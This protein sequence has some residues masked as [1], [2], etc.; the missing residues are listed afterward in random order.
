MS[1]LPSGKM[2]FFLFNYNCFAFSTKS[3]FRF[4]LVLFVCANMTT[5]RYTQ[6]KKRH[7]QSIKKKKENKNNKRKT[8][9][10]LFFLK[11]NTKAVSVQIITSAFFC[12]NFFSI[13]DNHGIVSGTSRGFIIAANN[14]LT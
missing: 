9:K 6:R 11:K 10:M 4:L 12:L 14:V 3:I 7:E 5:I 2:R 8:H 13:T 1:V